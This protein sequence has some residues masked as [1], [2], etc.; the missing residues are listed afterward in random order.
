MQLLGACKNVNHR[1]VAVVNVGERVVTRR[2][3]KCVLDS[4]AVG[5]VNRDQI[6]TVRISPAWS[7]W[8][9]H[10]AEFVTIASAQLCI[11]VSTH[12]DMT[13]NVST[14]DDMGVSR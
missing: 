6:S 4:Q 9:E 8:A 12:D 7:V 11:N 5:E 3:K 2:G 14:R 1:L 13:V 10:F